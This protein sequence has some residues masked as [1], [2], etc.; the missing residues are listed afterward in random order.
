VTGSTFT[1]PNAIYE[2]G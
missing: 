2:L 1:Q